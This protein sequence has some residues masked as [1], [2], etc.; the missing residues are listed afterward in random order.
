VCPRVH[1]LEYGTQKVKNILFIE[2]VELPWKFVRSKNE[3]RFQV[4]YEIFKV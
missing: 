3:N 2:I 4:E 1:K